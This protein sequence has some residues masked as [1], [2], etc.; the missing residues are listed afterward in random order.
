MING[1]VR[2]YV[3][4]ALLA[5][6]LPTV[7]C[8]ERPEALESSQSGIIYGTDDRTEPGESIL[9]HAQTLAAS[10]GALVSASLVDETD[11]EHI[12]LRSLSLT[13]K[14]HVCEDERFASQPTAAGCSG[15]LVAP[16]L[17]V[18]AGH[19]VSAAS[20]PGL[21]VVFNYRASP[22]SELETIAAEDVYACASVAARVENTTVDYALIRLDR[23]VTGRQPAPVRVGDR[24]LVRGT[25]LLTVG[26][27]SG[28]PQKVAGGATVLSARSDT[29]DYFSANLDAFPSNSGSGVFDLESGELAGILVRGPGGDYTFDA[30]AGCFRPTVVSNDNP[31]SIESTYVARAIAGFCATEADAT[32]CACGDGSCVA[33]ARETTSSCPLD[34]GSA[35]GDGACNGDETAESC[36]A[37][38]GACGNA[39]C[40]SH[41][42]ATLGC[43]E[44][45][46][47][48]DGFSC[49]T[50]T[51][52][53][54]LGNANADS[55]VDA[56]DVA[57]LQSALVGDVP[58]AFNSLSADVDCDGKLTAS[59]A[60]ALQA[61]LD[62][63]QVLPCQAVDSL[64][65]GLRHTCALAHGRVRCFGDNSVSQLGGAGPSRTNAAAAQEVELPRTVVQI[66][67]GS[68][69]TCA[70]DVAGQVTC[71]G[72]N[73]FGQ[74]GSAQPPDSPL[75]QVPLA[76]AAKEARAGVAHS[77]ALLMDGRVQC[78]GDNSKGQLGQ[79]HAQG[80]A[81][82]ALR[83][84]A[85]AIA[86]GS[87]HTCALLQSGAVECWG[88]NLIGQLGLG[89]RRPVGDDELPSSEPAV[90][91][92]GPA[93]AVRAAG[94]HSCALLSDGGAVCW[95][96][97]AF[98][99]LGY[100]SRLPIGDDELPLSAGVIAAGPDLVDLSLGQ[101]RTCGLY[102][103][104]DVRCW[105]LN[106]G[107]QL[108]YGHTRLPAP[109]SVP[110]ALAPVALGGAA[111]ALFTGPQHTCA[112]LTGGSVRCWGVN[113]SGQLGN[114]TLAAVGDDETPAAAGALRLFGQ[115]GTW[116]RVDDRGLTVWMMDE[117]S[118][119]QSSGIALYVSNDAAPALSRFK[120]YYTFNVAERGHPA[121]GL[122]DHFTPWSDLTLAPARGAGMTL[123]LAFLQRLL[124]PGD[125]TSW[126]DHGGE[127]LRLH[128][129]DWAPGWDTRND[130]SASGGA[131][132]RTWYQTER[133]QL[134]DEADTVLYGWE[135]L[136]D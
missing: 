129:A 57:A 51:C 1:R 66:A 104:G 15:T 87:Y 27:P 126:G 62:G 79:P 105:G 73:Q 76:V 85:T 49:Q 134:V 9:A 118:D 124:S 64:A 56:T 20:C 2:G 21:R 102:E 31:L 53:S 97:N 95:G 111:S 48:P 32:L 101:S 37:D 83:E 39:V 43:C 58:A 11:A 112:I 122:Q 84:P 33:S 109:G 125:V 23:A 54:A 78:W 91:L 41:E 120:L 19:C 94:L 80:I 3:W 63:E 121:V 110:S 90:A 14:Q 132:P 96:E 42:V 135:R 24:A 128:F 72:N 106:S 25:P 89:H 133:V 65:L 55:Q 67:A 50:G 119:A 60:A 26:H 113:A 18:T 52:A 35:C 44:D 136:H 13:E 92:P 131:R 107:G 69:H 68:Q 6:V 117:S 17:F 28:L 7:G 71:W 29:R 123:E 12:A 4:L 115:L 30:G 100:A 46:G 61:S 8:S 108:G 45:C 38:C 88:D 98:G 70:L 22:R 93:K 114:G 81:T 103:G 34:C 74:L 127:K 40:E 130:Y 10:S 75:V 77:C 36:Y 99:Q 16:D 59:D 82:A 47:C 86:S 5:G 116:R